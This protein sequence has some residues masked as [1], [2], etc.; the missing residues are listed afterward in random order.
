MLVQPVGGEEGGGS[1]CLLMAVERYHVAVHVRMSSP[2]ACTNGVVPLTT[3]SVR[4][5]LVFDFMCFV[6]ICHEFVHGFVVETAAS[7]A[8]VNALSPFHSCLCVLL[9]MC[10]RLCDVCVFA[11]ACMHMSL[12]M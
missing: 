5:L 8:F 2:F 12:C 1:G 7:V 6:Y 3:N 10:L 4:S 11:L 9:L